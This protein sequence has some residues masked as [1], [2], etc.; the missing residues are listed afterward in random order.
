MADNT[1]VK[2]KKKKKTRYSWQDVVFNICNYTFF[3]VFTLMC[4]FPFYYIFINTISDRDL[5][6]A[7]AIT[8]LPQGISFQHGCYPRCSVVAACAVPVIQW[9]VYPRYRFPVHPEGGRPIYR[10]FP[11]WECQGRGEA[12]PV[13]SASAV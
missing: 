1:E 8:L 6:K 12:L 10:D 13:W 4:V 9:P 2:V 5:V 11:M 3:A 7:G